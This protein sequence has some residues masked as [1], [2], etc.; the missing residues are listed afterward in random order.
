MLSNSFKPERY[1][2]SMADIEVLLNQFSENVPHSDKPAKF[3]TW[4]IAEMV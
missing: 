3:S 4:N 1:L 2:K